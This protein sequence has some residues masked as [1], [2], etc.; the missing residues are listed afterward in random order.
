MMPGGDTGD[1]DAPD[2]GGRA[3]RSSRL[4]PFVGGM[5]NRLDQIIRIVAIV[6]SDGKP[7]FPSPLTMLL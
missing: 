5:I 3:F 4:P 7:T 6:G 2:P 1:S